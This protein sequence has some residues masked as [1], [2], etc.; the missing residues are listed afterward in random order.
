MPEFEDHWA[1]VSMKPNRG[2][3]VDIFPANLR[4]GNPRRRG[5]G[6]IPELKP[7]GARDLLIPPPACS[8]SPAG[9][10]TV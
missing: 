2:L 1:S 8:L 3:K 9:E 7:G 10:G 5:V 6:V 4:A